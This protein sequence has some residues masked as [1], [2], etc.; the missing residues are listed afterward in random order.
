MLKSEGGVLARPRG[1]KQQ[2]L[3]KV[4]AVQLGSSAERGVCIGALGRGAA[5]GGRNRDCRL[6]LRVTAGTQLTPQSDRHGLRI[7]CK[8]T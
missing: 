6:E 1:R 7:S 4:L 5:G 3:G 2:N 8:S